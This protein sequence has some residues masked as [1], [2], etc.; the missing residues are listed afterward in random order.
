MFI[1]GQFVFGIHSLSNLIPQ[2]RGTGDHSLSWQ[3]RAQGK[4]SPYA[5]QYFIARHTHTHSHPHSD[6]NHIDMPRN[7]TCTSLGCGSKQGDL[8]KTQADMGRTCKHRRQWLQTGII[9]FFFS[10]QHYM[11]ITKW[12][13]I[14]WHYSRNCAFPFAKREIAGLYF[15]YLTSLNSPKGLQSFYFHHQLLGILFV[16]YFFYHYTMLWLFR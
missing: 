4:N 5:G 9:F 13:W 12:C 15:V 3:L 7:L 1:L 11:K 16:P 14:K 8:E 10:H 6:C 2:C